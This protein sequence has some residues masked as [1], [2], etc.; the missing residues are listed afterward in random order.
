MMFSF[1]VAAC[2]VR[3][4][5]KLILQQGLHRLVCV[6]GSAGIEPDAGV[7]QSRPG[8]AADAAANQRVRPMIFQKASQRAVTAANRADDLRGLNLT[9]FYRIEFKIFTVA[10]VLEYLSVFI[11]YCNFH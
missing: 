3:I 9:V 5:L 7:C 6:S 11:C 2:D 1:V 8:A 10:K 4:I